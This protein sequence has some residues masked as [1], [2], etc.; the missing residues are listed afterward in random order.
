MLVAVR[1]D[2]QHSQHHLLADVEAVD[3]HDRQVELTQRPVQKVVHLLRRRGNESPRHARLL[4]SD[5][6]PALI[7]RLEA[8]LVLSSAHPAEHLFDDTLVER[9]GLAKCL[10]CRQ[11]HL[12]APH[13]PNYR[14][15]HRD[16]APTNDQLALIVA[17]P[18]RFTLELLFPLRTAQLL[19]IVFEQRCQNLHARR[20]DQ[21]SEPILQS[22]DHPYEGQDSLLHKPRPNAFR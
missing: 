2:S 6:F 9:V 1:I 14:L 21:F 5:G 17:V 4:H 11:T 20:H 19:P 22:S 3:H 10:P 15:H 16:L 18:I 7:E 12:S 8:T 13:P